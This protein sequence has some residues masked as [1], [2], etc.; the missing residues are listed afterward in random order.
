MQDARERVRPAVESAELEWPLR[1]VVVNLSPG[2]VR[3]EGP[4]STF[5]S[6]M[7]CSRRPHRSRTNVLRALAFAGEVSLKGE[8]CTHARHPLVAIAAARAGLG[9]VDRSRANAVEAA[10]VEG[11]HV[12]G[13]RDDAGG[14]GLPSRHVGAAAVATPTDEAPA[15]ATRRSVG[16]ARAGA[17]APGARGRGG[18]RS[19]PADGR[20]A[21][22]PARRCSRGG[23]RRSFPSSRATK[24]SR[25][26]SCIRSRGLLGGDGPPPRAS[27]PRAAPFGLDRGAAGRRE[28]VPAARRGLL[29]HHGVLFLDEFTEFRRDAVESLRQPLEDGRVVITRA[30]DRWSSRR[31]SPW[32]P[33]PTLPVRVRR[34]RARRVR[35]QARPGPAVPEQ[36]LGAAARSH[37]HPAAHPPA[38]QGGAAR[39]ISRGRPPRWRASGSRRR[40]TGS[41]ARWAAIGVS[42]NAHLPGPVARRTCCVVARGGGPARA[43]GREPGAHRAWVRPRD[44]GRP[45]RR[46]PR[47]LGSRRGRSSRRGA[48]VPEPASAREVLARAG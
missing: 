13:A 38:H 16:G 21:R 18:R 28:R 29:A 26:R 19:Q 27:V 20:F 24:R 7:A 36:A 8:L 41:A 11:L 1:R 48:F 25:Q 31:G 43:G 22:A 37:R 32:W 35:V 44:Q 14:R 39:L 17:G 5:R 45:H 34:R 10:Q 40:A 6:S 46:R 23:C 33:R 4:G 12:V 42:C 2:N 3:K 30:A 47:R 15:A 9:R